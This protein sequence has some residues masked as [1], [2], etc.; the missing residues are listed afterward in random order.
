MVTGSRY[1]GRL[2]G[3]LSFLAPLIG[4]LSLLPILRHILTYFSLSLRFF[5]RK[6]RLDIRLA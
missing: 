3:F 2:L 5:K 1:H 4:P 6:D